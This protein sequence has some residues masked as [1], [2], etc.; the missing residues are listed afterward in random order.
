MKKYFVT[1]LFLY[2]VGVAFSQEVQELS[3]DEL[4]QQLDN[5]LSRFWSIIL[6]EN[7]AYNTGDLVDGSLTTNVLNFQ[8]SLPVP[9]GKAKM[10]LVRPV[11]PIVTGPAVNS[12]GEIIGTET[13]FGDMQV[14]SL[15][16]PDK[17]GGVVWGAGLTFVFPT[18]SSENL[19][20]GKYQAKP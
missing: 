15:Y 4:N 9:V 6:Q 20:S 3:I 7:L 1:I 8:P 19:G 16:G 2:S 18:A 10:L 13:G 17:K 12:S 14:F 11:F 5:P